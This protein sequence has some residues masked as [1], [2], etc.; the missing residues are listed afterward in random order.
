[1]S[2]IENII[3]QLQQIDAFVLLFRLVII[4]VLSGLIGWERESWNKPAG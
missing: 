2:F 3:S 4:V 1:M